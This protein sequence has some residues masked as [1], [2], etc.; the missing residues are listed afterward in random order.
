VTDA[1]S[2]DPI[3]LGANYPAHT[4]PGGGM[5]ARFRGA[6]PGAA[7]EPE[8]WVASVTTRWQEASSGLSRLPDGRLLRDA[9]EVDPEAYLGPEHVA[10][11]GRDP[12]LLVKLLDAAERRRQQRDEHDPGDHD[13]RAE[14]R[15]RRERMEAAAGQILRRGGRGGGQGGL[16]HR[17]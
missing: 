7:P 13:E 17:A 11:Y 5:S 9:I 15:D 8:D 10:A 3:V 16:S 4:Y 14:E 6:D 2:L 12:G 1:T